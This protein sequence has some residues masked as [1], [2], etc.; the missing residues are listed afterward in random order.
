VLYCKGSV[1]STDG[2]MIQDGSHVACGKNDKEQRPSILWNEGE[3]RSY[4]HEHAA[5]TE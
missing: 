3:C 1:S 4:S 5:D 2:G